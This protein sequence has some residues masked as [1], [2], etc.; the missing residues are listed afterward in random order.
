MDIFLLV[1]IKPVG[2]AVW[3]NRFILFLTCVFISISVSAETVY[4]TTNPDGSVEF[5]DKNIVDSEEVEVRKPITYQAPRLPSPNLPV[6]KLS[7]KFEYSLVINEPVDDSTIVGKLDVL[8]SIYTNPNLKIGH[9]HQ[10]RY[11]LAGKIILSKKIKETFKNVDR[12]THDLMVS[13]IDKTGKVISPVVS[14]TFHMKRHFK[15]P[16]VP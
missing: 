9:N 13:I 7:P 12:G 10:I 6:K 1:Y 5:T 3:M 16:K 8:V 15:K 14:R 11:E 4:K 2:Y